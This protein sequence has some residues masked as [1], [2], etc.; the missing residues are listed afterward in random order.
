MRDFGSIK[1]K[2]LSI[3]SITLLFIGTIG[4]LFFTMIDFFKPGEP[5]FGINQLAGFIVSVI[6]T[7][8][9]LRKIV[10]PENRLW[11]GILF[12]VYLS[13]IMFMGLF[14]TN[15]LCSVQPTG[16][17]QDFSYSFSDV[18]INI[19]GF[20]PLGY[21]MVSYFL[22]MVHT[23]KRKRAIFLIAASGFGISLT[24]EML[25]YFI[26]RTSSLTDVCSNGLGMML[27][28]SFYLLEKRFFT[29]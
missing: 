10:L 5:D 13:G 9:G 23:H 24:I 26:G 2:T 1:N 22:P 17:L 29:R 18:T 16:I 19:L 28:I 21:L 7:F 11:D 25:Q 12:F 8:A 14:R 6:V 20:I 15:S 4:I 3:G 27:G